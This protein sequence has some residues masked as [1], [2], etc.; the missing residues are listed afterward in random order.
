MGRPSGIAVLGIVLE[1]TSLAGAQ[2][3]SASHT[4]PSLLSS[5][6]GLV[7]V[8]TGEQQ[9]LPQPPQEP[10]ANAKDLE[11]EARNLIQARYPSVT[12]DV[13]VSVDEQGVLE[14]S[15]T[16]TSLATKLDL[17]DELVALEDHNVVVNRLQVRAPRRRDNAIRREVVARLRRHP[18][19][20]SYRIGVKCKNQQ[21]TLAGRVPAPIYAQEA[22]NEAAQVRGVEAVAMDKLSAPP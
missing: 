17:N 21:V 20:K 22:L 13:A 3:I 5:D 4:D 8:G 14:L 19:L 2:V 15:G 16:V 9:P 18:I 6:Y 10:E 7:R 12:T 1:F 11:A